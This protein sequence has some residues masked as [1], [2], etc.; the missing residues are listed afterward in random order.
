MGFSSRNYAM[1][2]IFFPIQKYPVE[3]PIYKL[4]PK[5]RMNQRGRDSDVQ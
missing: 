3:I 2:C 4:N 5:G 1:T